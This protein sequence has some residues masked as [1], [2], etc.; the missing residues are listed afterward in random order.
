[1]EYYL[2]TQKNELL[3]FLTWMNLIFIFSEISQTEKDKYCLFSL[4]CGSTKINW[5]N[6]T[7]QKQIHGYGEQ[8]SGYQREG[9]KQVK[10]IKS[11]NKY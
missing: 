8:T 3:P 5:I 1:M 10:G 6:I 9:A 4:I 2:A 7:K 11:Y